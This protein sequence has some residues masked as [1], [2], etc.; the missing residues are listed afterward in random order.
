MLSY[1]LPDDWVV[2][3][4]Q[5]PTGTPI[6][7]WAGRFIAR[8]APVLAVQAFAAFRRAMPARLVMVGDGPL[9][10]QVRAIAESLGISEDVDIT[11][12]VGWDE[13]KSFYDS[14]AVLL[15]TS[16]RETF[17]API[18]EAFGRGLPAVA[19]DLHGIADAEVG[20]AAVKVPLPP[21]PPDLPGYVASALCT[22]LSDGE[23]ELRSKDAVNFAA[24]WVWS[25]KAV[26]ITR[27]YEE[28]T[29]SRD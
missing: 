15:F 10:E 18:L 16:L 17:G 2:S 11:G 14:A 20:T 7:L 21:R 24:Q 19:L 27:L 25:A 23:W 4:R 8:K 13:V 1:G 28:L 6:I 26:A 22:V 3:P 12:H 29:G 5:Q 9:R